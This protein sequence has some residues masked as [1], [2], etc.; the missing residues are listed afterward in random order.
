MQRCW[1]AAAGWGW[2]ARDCNA[3]GYDPCMFLR[4][5]DLK[6]RVRCPFRYWAYDLGVIT[7]VLSPTDHK[8]QK[9]EVSRLNVGPLPPQKSRAKRIQN[10][11]P[12]KQKPHRPSKTSNQRNN[13]SKGINLKKPIT[14]HG[15]KGSA[16]P[17]EA[18]WVA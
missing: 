7:L 9:T 4:V 16:K 12:R 13:K 18:S 14:N 3:V 8:S 10:R 11:D 6:L 1:F 15:R 17:K 5:Q 2:P